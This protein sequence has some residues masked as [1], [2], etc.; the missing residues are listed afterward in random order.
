MLRSVGRLFAV[1]F[2]ASSLRSILSRLE[3]IAS[4][5]GLRRHNLN[6]YH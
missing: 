1:S 6:Q 2:E 5:R 3:S 4:M